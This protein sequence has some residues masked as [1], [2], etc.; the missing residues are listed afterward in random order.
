MREM[1]SIRESLFRR[2]AFVQTSQTLKR[3]MRPGLMYSASRGLEGRAEFEGSILKRERIV[4]S[5]HAY[6]CSYLGVHQFASIKIEIAGRSLVSNL[7][8]PS[9]A[10]VAEELYQFRQR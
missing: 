7:E 9:L 6:Q 5:L 4:D 2:H 8:S 10:L 1:C 3:H